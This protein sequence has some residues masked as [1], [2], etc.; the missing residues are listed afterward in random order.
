MASAP[1]PRAPPG[2]KDGPRRPSRGGKRPASQPKAA[3]F[4]DSFKKF[5]AQQ[6]AMMEV[7]SMAPGVELSERGKAKRGGP[8]AT[9]RADAKNTLSRKDYEELVRTGSQIPAD[10][11]ADAARAPSA[12]VAQSGSATPGR[13]MDDEAASLGDAVGLRDSPEALRA[14]EPPVSPGQNLRV[15][16]GPDM[17]AEL[18]PHPPAAARPVQPSSLPS[19]RRVQMKRDALG[20]ALSTR[21]RVPTGTGSRFPNCSAQPPLGATMGHGLLP[22]TG[23]YE[24]FYFPGVNS[25]GLGGSVEDRLDAGIS[26]DGPGGPHGL[27]VSKNP[28][29]AKRLFP[30]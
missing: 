5:E 8:L 12:S 6:P 21:E 7:M 19:F 18:V 10:P 4:L 22:G 20:Y 17:G 16:R 27:I 15:V 14:L 23:K 26:I 13:V 28:E 30:S 1:S 25:L 11:G 3:A 29:L 24:E 9:P 2:S